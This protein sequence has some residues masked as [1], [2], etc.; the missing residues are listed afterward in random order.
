MAIAR[1]IIKKPDILVFDEATSSLDSH[2]EGEIKKA[3]AE[4][5]RGV[6]TITIA[7]RF[8]TVVSADEILLI[9]NGQIAERGTHRQLLGR[10]GEYAR[11][12]NLQTQRQAEN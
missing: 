6:S 12:Y 9:A 1:A 10:R 4:V 5:S 8:S 11:L 2:S 7:H 3:I